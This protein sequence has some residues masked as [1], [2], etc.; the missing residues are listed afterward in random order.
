MSLD[1]DRLVSR[2][3]T[4][5]NQIDAMRL[6][7][8]VAP[9]V[10]QLLTR[11]RSDD[12]PRTVLPARVDS[13]T[14]W[15][16]VAQTAAEGR[17]LREEMRSWLGAPITR[18]V[19]QVSP[20]SDD[21]LD[22]VAL[23]MAGTH[24][25]AL[26]AHV[27]P[28]YLRPAR[29]AMQQLLGLWAI[30][31]TRQHSVPRPVGRVLR[32]F[33]EAILVRDR[34][35]AE[36]ALDEV[37]SRGLLTATNAR[38]LLV[39]LLGSLG[40]PQDLRDDPRL[41]GISLVR[42]PPRITETLARAADQLFIGPAR[43]IDRVVID[44]IAEELEECW[45]GLVIHAAQVRSPE[46]ARC[47]AVVE[48]VS[49]SPRPSIVAYLRSAWGNDTVVEQVLRVLTPAGV[50][51]AEPD[52]FA[53]IAAGDLE[54]ALALCETLPVT[55]AN[56]GIAVFAAHELG[57]IDGAVR[58]LRL[59]DR[60]PANELKLLLSQAVQVIRVDALRELVV[61]ATTAGD[62]LA[63]LRAPGGP[64][65][66]R[67][68]LLND[69]ALTVPMDSTI[70]TPRYVDEVL[71]ELI[72]ALNDSRRPVVRDALPVLLASLTRDG[73]L[74]PEAVRLAIEVADVVLSS[75]AGK[76]ERALAL[77]I[78]DAAFECGCTPEEYRHLLE[79]VGSHFEEVGPR[80]ISFVAD[81]VSLVLDASAQDRSARERFV[82]R[83]FAA[84]SRALDRLDPED[85]LV[86]RQ[87]FRAVGS[88]MPE[89]PG[90][91]E[92][93]TPRDHSIRV[94]GIYSLEESAARR[95]AGWIAEIVDGV[96]VRLSHD[97]VNSDRLAS[98][99]R[100]SQV[101][102]VQTSK[103]THAATNAISAAALGHTPIVHVNGRGASALLREF[104]RWLTLP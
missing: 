48:S 15:Y 14:R 6:P 95:A 9:L 98:T 24:G 96:D 32:D 27:N 18:G 47:L 86:L 4:S 28:K 55:R 76:V 90:T 62:W 101:M 41:S 67:L 85:A 97:H 37:R 69:W 74:R 99:V 11:A 7:D 19:A 29:E 78:M 10:A 21:Q 92:T 2:F 89:A 50:G 46:S 34:G 25:V 68:D 1:T 70:L 44:R 23:E 54:A 60:L 3:F 64:T 88:A 72:D 104:V 66:G 53:L 17:Q 83:G 91:A 20:N 63:W 40:T 42:R 39:E 61:E 38:F 56:V 16:G 75:G 31:P 49:E 94:V 103:A 81:A 51:S 36:D 79:A 100:S 26:V 30:S 102:L 73:G 59:V 5:P 45:P 33:Y 57:L 77:D 58:A 43:S 84:A 93:L 80:S 71:I 22:R 8:D 87:V 12:R 52:P 65:A 35:A 82:A 13:E